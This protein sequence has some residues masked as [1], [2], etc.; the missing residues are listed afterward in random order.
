MKKTNEK[1][2]LQTGFFQILFSNKLCLP[3]K[4]IFLHKKVKIKIRLM[5]LFDYFFPV[6]HSLFSFFPSISSNFEV[7]SSFLLIILSFLRGT[8]Q[9][10]EGEIFKSK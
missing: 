2:M 9:I 4:Q 1:L 7:V 10:L 3:T 6:F 8:L 5:L